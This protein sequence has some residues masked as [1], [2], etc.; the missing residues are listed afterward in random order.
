[1]YKGNETSVGAMVVVTGRGAVQQS[2]FGQGGG[3][4]KGPSVLP[5]RRG[6]A[7]GQEWRDE[8]GGSSN[9]FSKG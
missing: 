5:S 9:L 2:Y 3:L 6:V 4:I 8:S 1:M 7:C